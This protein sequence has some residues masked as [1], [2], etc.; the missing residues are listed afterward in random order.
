MAGQMPKHGTDNS[1]L[2][3]TL[4]QRGKEH[5]AVKA[6]LREQEET[7]SLSSREFGNR[8]AALS[9]A[10]RKLEEWRAENET[11][12][13]PVEKLVEACDLGRLLRDSESESVGWEIDAQAGEGEYETKCEIARDAGGEQLVDTRGGSCGRYGRCGRGK[14][15]PVG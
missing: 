5:A 8:K 7:K 11:Q 14:R 1:N 13:R 6:R 9:S 10:R 3:Q 15:V 12:G 2:V 4:G